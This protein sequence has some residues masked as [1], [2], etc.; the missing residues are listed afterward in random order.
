MTM[1]TRVGDKQHEYTSI[2]TNPEIEI[3]W[4]VWWVIVTQA[5]DKSSNPRGEW[6]LLAPERERWTSF[7][8]DSNGASVE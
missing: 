6:V 3:L 5:A 2:K 8:I 1:M 7:F 4:R